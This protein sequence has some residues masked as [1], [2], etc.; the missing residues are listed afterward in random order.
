MVVITNI[1][2]AAS[3][4]ALGQLF[5]EF[6]DIEIEVE[7]VIPMQNSVMPLFWVGVTNYPRSG[8]H[9]KPTRWW[10]T[11]RYSPS[12]RIERYSS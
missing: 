12:R 10:S 5:E 1:T 3:E 11:S 2:V 8:T 4:F 7:R 9:S 6:P